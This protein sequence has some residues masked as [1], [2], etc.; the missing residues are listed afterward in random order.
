MK[1]LSA[2]EK[3]V[4]PPPSACHDYIRQVPSTEPSTADK[5]TMTTLT[6]AD[7]GDLECK[8]PGDFFMK[9]I[10][11]DDASVQHYTGFPNRKT[12]EGYCSL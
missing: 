7:I 4:C 1:P 12:L 3:P 5:S 10:L 8:K 9:K 6:M 2:G 11:K